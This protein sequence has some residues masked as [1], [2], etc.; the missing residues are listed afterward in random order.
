MKTL[1]SWTARRLRWTTK[2]GRLFRCSKTAVRLPPGS[3]L[4]YYAFD[5]LQLNGKDLKDRPLKERRV[6][7]EKVIGNSGVLL[8]QSLPGT[9]G[10]IIQA[11]KA[12]RS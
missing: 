1:S 4:V 8:S 5:L 3:S 2:V 7:L 6:L 12:P 10:Q 11:V 9:L